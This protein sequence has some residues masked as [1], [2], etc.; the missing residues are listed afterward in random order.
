MVS[1]NEKEIQ[2]IVAKHTTNMVSEIMNLIDG[3]PEDYRQN[4]PNKRRKYQNL[5]VYLRGL[6]GANSNKGVAEAM[7]ISLASYHSLK[8]HYYVYSFHH[9]HKLPKPTFVRRVCE[10]IAAKESE[11]YQP[12]SAQEVLDGLIDAD[13]FPE[14]SFM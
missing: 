9:P 6:F 2:S 5:D 10:A 7:G 4:R 1:I 3:L 14:G 11:K 12:V 13:Y 8:D